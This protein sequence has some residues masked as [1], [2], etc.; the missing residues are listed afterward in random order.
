MKLNKAI[1]SQD[2]PR[3]EYRLGEE[4]TESSPVERDLGF[5][6]DNKLD[7]SQLCALA[8][9]KANSILGCINRWVAAGRG[10]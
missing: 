5:L 7:T 10:R 4:L 1:L 8:V 2:N 3:Y 9:Q 6:T